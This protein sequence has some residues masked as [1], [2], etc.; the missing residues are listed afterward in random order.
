MDFDLTPEQSELRETVER[1][2]QEQLNDDLIGRDARGGF[3]ADNWLKCSKI[4]L[5][6]LPI[7]T[8]YG[9]TQA[10]AVTTMVA[11]EALGYGCRDNGLIF[12]L[13]AHLWAGVSPI[14]R[15]GSEQQRERYLPSMCDGTLIAAHAMSE[16]DSGSDSFSLGTSVARHDDGYVINGGKT[17]IT[18]AP[19]ADVFLVFATENRNRG[20][21]G[22]SA[23]L[24]D[25]KTP[26]L[27]VGPPVSKMGLRT[28]PMAEVYFDDCV[29]PE[30]SLLGPYCGGSAIFNW[31]MER[32]RTFILAS[33][34]GTMRRDLERSIE[35]ARTRKQFGQPIGA[36]QAVSHRIVEMKLRV[37][38]AQLLLHR[39]AW[40]TDQGR[41]TGLDA[42]LAKIWTSESFVQSGLDA[43]Q[44]HGG[45]GFTTEYELERDLRDAVAGR[46]YSGTS[47]VQR[48][49]AA[50][51]LGLPTQS[52]S[53]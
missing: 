52:M 34:V 32:E 38:A 36:F 12:S 20:F 29:V 9:G 35:H 31:T 23:F 5:L 22:V 1:F 8:R 37:E 39:L 30:E 49:L 19:V 26:G 2:A 25:R 48:N 4:G 27:T 45:Y 15:F 6:G 53:R 14:I 13:H 24:V 47:E 3:A 46:I 41:P 28:S 42:A 10:D 43:V 44:I 7:P 17:F 33:A 11:L 40:K 51:H 21:A 16:P 50:R 18:N